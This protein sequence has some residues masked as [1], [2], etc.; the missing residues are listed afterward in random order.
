MRSRTIFL[1]L[2]RPMAEIVPTMVEIS[3]AIRATL[4]VVYREAIISRDSSIC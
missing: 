2:L 1:D 3:V 4:K